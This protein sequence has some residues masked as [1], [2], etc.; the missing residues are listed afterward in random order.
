MD[1]T[2]KKKKA[3]KVRLVIL[4]VLLFLVPLAVVG[5][6]LALNANDNLKD[7]TVTAIT[8]HFE[9]ESWDVDDSEDIRFF[10]DMVQGGSV[11]DETA[12]PL[13]DY[14]H[15]RL[16][17]HKLKRDLS[18]ELLLSDS[19]NDCV[20]IDPAGDLF[21]IAPE[22]AETLLIHPRIT[23][24]A[25]SFA[26]PPVCSL[27][28]GGK[29]TPT[30]VYTG[31]W[32]YTKVDGN[33]TTLALA[34]T[35]A[36][37]AVLPAGEALAFSFSLQPDFVSIRVIGEKG[38]TLFSGD[39]AEMELLSFEEDT[40]LSVTVSAEWYGS[41][42]RS[43]RGNISYEF[44][45]LYDVPSL[46]VLSQRTLLPGESFEIRILYSAADTVAVTATFQAGEVTQVRE[47]KE[48]VIRV[49]VDAAVTPNDYEIVLLGVDVDETF[50][51]TI[52]APED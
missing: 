25:M 42:E 36:R 12:T 13:E 29:E 20:Y 1:K 4:V 39:P 11:I 43:Y 14:R 32:T 52:L 19:V 48:L 9:D 34:E 41:E 44:A 45:V 10:V 17:F 21:L 31:E 16:T 22:K 8:M 27:S 15:L 51:V 6:I 7:G 24:L 5:V 2:A 40:S 50:P 46:C 23:G 37:D 18:Y 3:G 30:A 26:A 35:G 33:L 49:P 47:G 28:A 38:N